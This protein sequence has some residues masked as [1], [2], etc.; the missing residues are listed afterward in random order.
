MNQCDMCN[1]LPSTPDECGGHPL[2]K[3]SIEYPAYVTRNAGATQYWDSILE[4]G[5][6]LG[7]ANNYLILTSRKAFDRDGK[8]CPTATI[9][10]IAQSNILFIEE[11]PEPN[12]TI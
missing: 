6:L 1:M 4:V 2:V 10:R 5:W 9:S 12:V 11:V 8:M 3:V 7:Y